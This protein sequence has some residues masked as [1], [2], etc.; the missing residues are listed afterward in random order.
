MFSTAVLPLSFRESV[1]RLNTMLNF[2]GNFDTRRV[3]L[4][5]IVTGTHTAAARRRLAALV[6]SLE[7]GDITVEPLVRSGSPAF[8]IHRTAWEEN[9]DFICIPWKRK[10]V[11]QRM[12]AG[13]T[14]KD[15]IRLSDIPVFVFKKRPRQTED[16]PLQ[17]ILYAT[18]FALTDAYV[19]P[20]LQYSRLA[21]DDLVI[22]NVGQRAPDPH[23]EERREQQVE[24]NLERLAGE[25]EAN[26]RSVEQVAITGNHR[27]AIVRE[28]R[29]RDADLI[30][31][32]KADVESTLSSMMLGSTAEEVANAA[33]C[34]VFIVG[35]AYEPQR[36]A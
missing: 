7:A 30:V 5:H 23:T 13:S 26:Y 1:E 20:Y 33:R 24:N 15:V 28:A 21:A 22:L 12:I 6:E 18:N 14:T 2:L 10:S 25:V 29:R 4:T 17:R 31:I 32:G 8:E 9:A 11:V 36:N 35:R 27:R 34:S 3:I 19:V 16:A